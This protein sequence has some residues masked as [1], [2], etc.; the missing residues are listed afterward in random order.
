MLPRGH[1]G[2]SRSIALGV[3]ASARTTGGPCLWLRSCA[4]LDGHDCESS[5]PALWEGKLT[6]SHK[7]ANSRH[8]HFYRC[9]PILHGRALL[10]FYAESPHFYRAPTPCSYRFVP[11]SIR[12]EVGASRLLRQCG[13]LDGRGTGPFV[14]PTKSVSSSHVDRQSKWNE[15]PQHDV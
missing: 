5:L 1:D 13:Q 6:G 14:L 4:V 8:Q 3:V 2:R 7:P 11:C 9:T 10:P 12:L 15:D